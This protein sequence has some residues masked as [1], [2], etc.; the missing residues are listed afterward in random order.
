ME[1]TASPRKGRTSVKPKAGGYICTT[2][3]DEGSVVK[4]TPKSPLKAPARVP[5]KAQAKALLKPTHTPKKV[6]SKVGTHIKFD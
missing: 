4:V 2:P 6:T 5:S 3:D 1:A